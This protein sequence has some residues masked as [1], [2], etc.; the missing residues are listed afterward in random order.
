MKSIRCESWMQSLLLAS[1]ENKG[2]S[3]HVLQ[4]FVK[5]WDE[6]TVTQHERELLDLEDAG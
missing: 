4:E 6:R 5:Q 3:Q 2:V 1:N